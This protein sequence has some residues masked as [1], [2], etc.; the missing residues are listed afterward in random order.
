MEGLLLKIYKSNKSTKL[1][2]AASLVCVLAGVLAFF[3]LLALA[4]LNSPKEAI[5]LLIFFAVP[6]CA[7]SLFRRFFNAPRPYE[8]Y[9]FYEIA[10]RDKKGSSFPSRHVFSAVIIAVFALSYSVVMGVILLLLSLILSV[11]RVLLGIHFIRDCVAGAL[12]GALS[13]IIGILLL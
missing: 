1:L 12:I 11:S 13:A 6:F 10:P 5:L 7:V 9:E 8:I 2:K 4:Y 3:A